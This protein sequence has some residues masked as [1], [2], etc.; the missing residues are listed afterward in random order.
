MERIGIG[1][2]TCKADERCTLLYVS[3]GFLDFTGY[4]R[5]EIR[6]RFRD[7]FYALVHPEDA[8]HVR[9][10]LARQKALGNEFSLEYRLTR[11]NGEPALIFEHSRLVTEN[12]VPCYYC[13]IFDASRLRNM[14]NKYK[15]ILDAMPCP[16]VL[17][18][19][20]L[21]VR[22]MNKA[23]E[24]AAGLDFEKC[25]NR[26]C[27]EIFRTPRCNTRECCY[28]R[29]K[30]NESP[31]VQRAPDGRSFQVAFSPVLDESG[32]MTGVIS[33][34]TD[35]T[36][37]C[38]L[39]E[40]LREGESRCLVALAQTRNAIW[41]FDI[42]TGT[43]YHLDSNLSG[44]ARPFGME[45]VI[46]D[47][48]ESLI[49][50]GRVHADSAA[51][52]RE[53]F[54]GIR[55]GEK[56]G[57]CTAKMS[58]PDYGE[59]WASLSYTAI[60]NAQGEPMRAI[61]L[62]RNVSEEKKKEELFAKER[63]YLR[64]LLAD[65]LAA[66]EIDLSEDRV[67]ERD[68]S[69]NISREERGDRDGDRRYSRSLG[70]AVR[71]IVHPDHK[72]AVLR[73]MNPEALINAYHS[74]KRE[75]RLEYRCIGPSGD[76]IWVESRAYLIESPISGNIFAF[77]HIKDISERKEKEL[78]LRHK[79]SFDELTGLYNRTT[80]LARIRDMLKES[81]NRIGALMLVDIDDFKTVND[82]F[83]HVFGDKVLSDTAARLRGVFRKR[84]M[85]GR[86]G[87]DEFIIFLPS[88]THKKIALEKA[89]RICEAMC[90][91]Y[92]CGEK[93]KTVSGS[94]GVAFFPEHGEEPGTLYE[95]ADIALYHAKNMGKNRYA[96]YSP[97]LANT[98]RDGN[99]A[100]VLD[101]KEEISG[102]GKTSDA[103]AV[104]PEKDAEADDSGAVREKRQDA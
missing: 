32:N 47:V 86:L 37:R 51:S 8:A 87:G 25:L 4:G 43:L 60:F 10:E 55:R 92:C 12:G 40:R 76:A 20:D 3:D 68:T 71:K 18:D 54:A 62:S 84:D 72:Q 101:H 66:Y 65:A 23:M 28:E 90:A 91:A 24:E 56:T 67:L 39:E 75:A 99:E 96:L 9:R 2:L 69:W 89:E 42:K 73:A 74:G 31:A 19:T 52:V 33:V 85:I 13:E 83:G 45:S 5:E 104:G 59:W 7:D 100:R 46:H 6:S 70:N 34:S 27:A 26:T 21:R 17:M 98:G 38:R 22:F 30:R 78:E 81:E 15:R 49:R 29:Y 41:E 93:R 82:T 16:V 79:A 95:K 14:A 35:I 58:T 63:E 1:M 102:P 64:S 44:Y 61:G 103:D 48:P 80:A 94:V 57:G 53:M 77:I 11:K 88:L 36:E 50:S 97:E